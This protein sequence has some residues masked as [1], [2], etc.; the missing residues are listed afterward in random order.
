M[1]KSQIKHLKLDSAP[2]I[3]NWPCECDKDGSSFFKQLDSLILSF[4]RIIK[5]LA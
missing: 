3:S 2:V 5:H 1:I 4:V